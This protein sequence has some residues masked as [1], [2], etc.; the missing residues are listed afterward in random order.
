MCSLGLELLVVCQLVKELTV[1]GPSEY[2]ESTH[3]HP[4]DVVAE[5]VHL[6]CDVRV[7]LIFAESP[8]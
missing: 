1:H 7:L 4:I 6:F 2:F 3:F 5:E 8:Y